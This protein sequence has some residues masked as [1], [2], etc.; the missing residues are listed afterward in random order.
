M[1]LE[2]RPAEELED[3]SDGDTTSEPDPPGEAPMTRWDQQ[4]SVTT[5]RRQ[6]ADQSLRQI[7]L[8]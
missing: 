3:F 8:Y 2:A 6:P 1:D 5:C 7:L 4:P